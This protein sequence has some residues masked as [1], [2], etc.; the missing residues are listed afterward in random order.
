ML[1]TLAHA[2]ALAL[3]LMLAP[4]AAMAAVV[5]MPPAA[6]VVADPAVITLAPLADY[7]IGIAALLLPLLAGAGLKLLANR[8]KIDRKTRAMMEL[9]VMANNAIAA[10]VDALSRHADN[11]TIEVKHPTVAAVAGYIVHQAPKLLR[12]ADMSEAQV[13]AWIG[14]MVAMPAPKPR[15]EDRS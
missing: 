9:E 11:L 2:G 7:L 8:L 4:V 10:G 13:A 3:V 6:V 1:K 14:R 5:D 12:D 15:R